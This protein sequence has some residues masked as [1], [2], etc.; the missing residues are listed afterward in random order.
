MTVKKKSSLKRP[1]GIREQGKVSVSKKSSIIQKRD[2]KNLGKTAHKRQGSLTEMKK[3]KIEERID[4]L[5]SF[6]EL[7][8]SP[9]VELD[10]MGQVQYLNPSAE[11]L[12]PDLR[13]KGSNHPW[14]ADFG[15]LTGLVN[16]HPPKAHLRE[17]RVG[18]SWYQQVIYYTPEWNRIRLYGYDIT[19]G[20]Q[21]EEELRRSHDEL[22]IRFQERTYD[23]NER[24]K[25]LN[26][27]SLISDVLNKPDIPFEKVFE[28]T[29]IMLPSAFQFPEIACARITLRGQEFKSQ[30]YRET[31]AWKLKSEILSRGKPVGII[32]L[33][34]LEEKP[35]CY[36]GPFLKE[37]KIIIDAIALQL[38]EYIERIETQADLAEQR[39]IL[40]GFFT[41]TITPL[42]LLDK[43]F[44]FIRVN[45]AYAKACQRDV[46]DF[47]GHNH[48]EFYPNKENEAIFRRVVES[49]VPF[50]AIEKAFAF[51]D[52]PE[53]GV[54]YWDWTLTPLLNATGEVEF[55]V[56]SLEDV[57][58]RRRAE[59][60]VKAERQ[61]FNDVLEMLPAY[62]VLLTP[63]YHVPFANRFFRERFGESHGRRCF[64]YLFGR[65]EP[66]EVCET[67]TV[68]KT[69]APH[70]WEWTGP[71]GRNYQVFDF[72]F[73]D[74]DGSNLILEIGIDITEHKQAE[75]ALRQNEE[76]LRNVLEL[77]PV[78]IWIT[79]KN[80][81]IT[82]GNPAGHHIWGGCRH[83]GI[84]K[85]GE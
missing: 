54:T 19:E 32:E 42:V 85:Y 33:N 58:E 5:A 31:A 13:S 12:F 70:E 57:T 80:G 8:P 84:E 66:C 48:F 71:D 11:S 35:V 36:E 59:D 62:L 51:P 22:E 24:V 9:I 79:D 25:K 20:K 68:L 18:D 67:Y 49:R 61:R 64:E 50:Q 46:S 69:M 34:Y 73:T 14:I 45:E 2:S 56:F 65:S 43:D 77:L 74:T 7:H 21:A 40:E 39:R 16:R 3:E 63:D 15:S 28:E 41:S 78:G 26:C 4:R 82:Q 55:L 81:V 37:E 72:P 75:E 6:P 30:N 1:K 17:K 29:A 76:L 83:V 10:L 52:H 27:L 60:A 53:W 23:L 44:N 38:G 47:P